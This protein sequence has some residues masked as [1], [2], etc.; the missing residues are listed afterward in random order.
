MDRNFLKGVEG[1]RINALLAGI[2]ANIRKPP[3]RL[4]ACALVLDAQ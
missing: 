3:G 1:D 4:L 2:G